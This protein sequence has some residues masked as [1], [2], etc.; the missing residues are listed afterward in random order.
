MKY[1]DVLKHPVP[2]C[3]MQ[4]SMLYW[5][6]WTTILCEE[7]DISIDR[8]E[9]VGSTDRF[10]LIDRAQSSNDC[11]NKE[12]K[13]QCRAAA[14][15]TE[16]KKMKYTFLN[17]ASVRSFK[18]EVCAAKTLMTSL[19]TSLGSRIK[20]GLQILSQRGQEVV[21]EIKK[22]KYGQ[23]LI[24]LKQGKRHLLIRIMWYD[25]KRRSSF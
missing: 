3:I 13:V 23:P 5:L 4:A 25:L 19:I 17:A 22:C 15:R 16:S 9:W 18:H 21:Y 20:F 10:Y 6:T 2:F 11:L 1:K 24:H 8:D 12:V 7:E 14:V